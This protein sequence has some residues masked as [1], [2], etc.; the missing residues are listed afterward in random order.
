MTAARQPIFQGSTSLPDVNFERLNGIPISAKVLATLRRR[1]L[2]IMEN[3]PYFA[4]PSAIIDTGAL[5]GKGTRIWHFSH[6][7]A[8]ASIGNYC[9]LGQN[10]FVAEGAVLGNGV[11][12]QNN[13]SVY[14]GVICE[15][16]VFLGPSMVFTNVR[17]PRSAV[18]RKSSFL[19]TRVCRGA[20]IGAGAVILCGHVIGAFA[21]VGAGT[22]VLGDVAP[23]ALVVGNPGRQ[24]GWMSEY[25]ERLHFDD[26]GVAICTG[27][28]V[29]YRLHAGIVHKSEPT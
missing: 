14:Q 6:V 12:V 3:L 4:H 24:I 25:G 26:Q 18:N 17:N 1:S 28:G 21:F 20:T 11:K 5:I 9:V 22:V 15:D 13:V 29:E 10:V 8:G 19:P 27:S 23:H 16:D 2:V 7:M